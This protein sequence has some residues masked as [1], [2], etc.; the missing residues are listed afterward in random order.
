MS[1]FPGIPDEIIEEMCLKMDS[2]SLV[3]FNKVCRQTRQICSDIIRAKLQHQMKT[4][5]ENQTLK[6]ES[7]DLLLK[8][9]QNIPILKVVEII[10]DESEIDEYGYV[11]FFEYELIVTLHNSTVIVHTGDD[12]QGYYDSRSV[13]NEEADRLSSTESNKYVKVNRLELI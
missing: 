6:P 4:I 10:S 7:R 9:Y 5:L 11:D 3:K 2:G 13:N 1:C 8:K 12:S